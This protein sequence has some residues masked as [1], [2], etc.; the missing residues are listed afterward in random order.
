MELPKKKKPV[1]YRANLAY[2]VQPHACQLAEFLGALGLQLAWP[3]LDGRHADYASHQPIYGTLCQSHFHGCF[4]LTAQNQI[5]H[6]TV[7]QLSD[8]IYITAVCPAL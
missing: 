8:Y 6:G 5:K 4:S 2:P 3:S 7:G 1:E